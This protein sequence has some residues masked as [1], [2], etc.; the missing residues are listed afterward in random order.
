MIKNNLTCPCSGLSRQAHLLFLFLFLL[1]GASA[2]SSREVI[3]EESELGIEE[4]GEVPVATYDGKLLAQ[5]VFDTVD[6]IVARRELL[7]PFIREFGDGTVVDQVMIRKV[8]ETKEDKPAYYLVGL[9]QRSGAFRSM[10]LELDLTSDNS[11][12]LSSKGSKHICQAGAG[13]S[14]CY[15]TFS[16]NRI[17]GCE[18]D[19]RAPG[20]NCSHKFSERNN[21]LKDVQL[22]NQRQGAGRK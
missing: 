14:F 13:C 4:E 17:T 1:L 5:V 2:C 6:Y 8:Q 21:L 12:Y 9:G 3:R 19:S 16:G 18:C 22:R 7:Q 11:L 20:N 15:F 10:A